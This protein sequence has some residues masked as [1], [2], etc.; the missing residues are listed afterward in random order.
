MTVTLNRDAL[1]HWCGGCGQYEVLPYA[2]ML[3]LQL[4]NLSA[5]DEGGEN[6]L[7]V[8]LVFRDYQ[9]V[10]RTTAWAAVDREQ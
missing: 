2:A 7:A 4:A 5:V 6:F 10:E 8:R 9:I 3:A 1:Q